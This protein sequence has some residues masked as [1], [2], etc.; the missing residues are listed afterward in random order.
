MHPEF[1]RHHLA[2]LTA[3]GLLWP[4]SAASQ[5]SPD[6]PPAPPQPLRRLQNP[7]TLR[8]NWRPEDARKKLKSPRSTPKPTKTPAKKTQPTPSGETQAACLGLGEAKR[9]PKLRF[10]FDE[11]LAYQ[12]TLSGVQVGRMESVVGRPVIRNKQRYLP[13]FGRGRTTTLI[14]AVKPMEG[15]IQNLVRPSDLMVQETKA[16]LRYNGERRWE[17][18]RYTQGHT[19]IDYL[20]KGKTQARAYTRNHAASDLLGLIFTARQLE[21]K[22]GLKFCQYAYVSRRLWRVDA[23]VLGTGEANTLAGPM[24]VY[25]V[26]VSFDREPTPGLYNTDRPHVDMILSLSRTPDQVPVAFDATMAG[27]DLHARLVRW[28]KGH[29]LP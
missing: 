5:P 10:G 4:L 19:A 26:K 1:R 12:L 6:L 9:A 25:R 2:L 21:L 3:F 14:A 20:M 16:E 23:E 18:A 17:R 27:V 8:P 29:A 15:R 28:K 13:L 24:P 22:P 7:Y 11:M